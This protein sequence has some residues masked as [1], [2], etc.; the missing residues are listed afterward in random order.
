M[1]CAEGMD[2]PASARRRSSV[3]PDSRRADAVAHRFF[4]VRRGDEEARLAVDCEILGTAGAV[5]SNATLR[6]HAS[7]IPFPKCS[8]RVGSESKGRWKGGHPAI[9]GSETRARDRVDERVSRRATDDEC[10]TM[11]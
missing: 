5:E 3:A 6:P 4:G 7:K 8:L 1:A 9:Y 2:G 10:L 11:K